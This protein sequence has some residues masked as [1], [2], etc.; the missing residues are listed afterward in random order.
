MIISLA[1]GILIGLL[2]SRDLGVTWGIVCGVGTF[3]ISQVIIML[4]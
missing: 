1:V 2:T 3:L 4:I